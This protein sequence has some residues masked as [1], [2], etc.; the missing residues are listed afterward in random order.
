MNELKRR[1][2]SAFTFAAL[3]FLSI[4]MGLHTFLCLHIL[5]GI[6]VLRESGRLFDM[7][8]WIAIHYILLVTL[9][10]TLF[11]FSLPVLETIFLVSSLIMHFYLLYFLFNRK[12]SNQTVLRKHLICLAYLT[13]GFAIFMKVSVKEGHFDKSLM[14]FVYLLIWFNDIFAY[15]LG[16]EFGK[17]KLFVSVSPNKTFEG[18][19]GGLILTL[20]ISIVFSLFFKIKVVEALLISFTISIVSPLGDFIESKFKRQANIKDSGSILPGHG[21]LYD[22]MD[23]TIFVGPWLYLVLVYL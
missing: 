3:I 8:K 4:E 22:R 16:K 23:G 19:A 10:L 13:M 1:T 12:A 5:I 21:G 15:F 6:L 7:G 18:I 9:Y 2:I 17:H 11:I 14:F 20:G